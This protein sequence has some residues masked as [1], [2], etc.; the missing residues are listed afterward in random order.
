M[1]NLFSKQQYKKRFVRVMLN[2][3]TASYEK[4]VR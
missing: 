4:S 3:L 1:L 2:F